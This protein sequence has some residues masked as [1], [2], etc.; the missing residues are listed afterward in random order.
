MFRVARDKGVG[1]APK[2]I[3]MHQHSLFSNEVGVEVG[4]DQIICL[5]FR[6]R[7]TLRARTARW[8]L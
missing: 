5:V 2:Q 1:I 6:P 3:V 8:S 4:D 7:L